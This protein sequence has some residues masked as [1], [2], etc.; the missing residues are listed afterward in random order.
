MRALQ[1]QVRNEGSKARMLMYLAV[2]EGKAGRFDEMRVALAEARA[3]A[4]AGDA[5][6]EFDSCVAPTA[7]RL[8]LLSGNPARAET[9]SRKSCADLERRGLTAYLASELPGLA[10]ALV[11]EGRLDEADAALQRAEAIVVPTDLDAHHGRTRARARLELAR[12]DL[13][14]AEASVKRSI[15]WVDQMQWPDTRIDTLL[16]HA[17]ILYAA[18]RY[19]EARAIAEQALTE[20]E[21]IEHQVYADRAREMLRSPAVVPVG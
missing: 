1:E 3:T 8:E 9:I 2:L 20:S 4:A 16:L 15:E 6:L 7:A 17:Q 13:A 21:A 14:A 5:S 19:D 12:G 11:A 10:E 18:T